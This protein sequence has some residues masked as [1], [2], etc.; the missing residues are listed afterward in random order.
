M[1]LKITGLVKFIPNAGSAQDE[2]LTIQN[3]SYSSTSFSVSSQDGFP[4]GIFFNPA[5]T[6]MFMSGTGSD[7]VYQYSLSTGFDL[8]TATYNSVSFSVSGQDGIPRGVYFNNNGTKMFI[9]G[10]GNDSVF[11]YTLTTGF[12]L[13]TAS[14]DSV[15]FSISGQ[16]SPEGIFFNSTGTRMFMV[17]VNTDAVYQYS[18]STGFDLSTAS[19]DSISFSVSGQDSSPYSIFFNPT[20]TKMFVLGNSTDSV[21]EY[22]L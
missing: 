2:N 9:A 10:G 17:G 7:T 1:G 6:K 21:Y 20:G 14:Y 3:A 18:L 13:S 22:D 8:S 12:D 19:Y 4:Q 15:S 11:Q 16:D 5:G